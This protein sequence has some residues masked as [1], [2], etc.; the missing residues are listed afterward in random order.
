MRRLFDI[1]HYLQTFK[2]RIGSVKVKPVDTTG[3]GDAFV[4]GFLNSL[5]SDLNLIKVI[6]FYIQGIFSFATSPFWPVFS[7]LSRMITQLC[8]GIS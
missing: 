8:V 2:G 4:G 6:Y 5:A 1:A 3:A 7:K